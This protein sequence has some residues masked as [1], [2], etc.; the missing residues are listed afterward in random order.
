MLVLTHTDALWV[1]FYK[2]RE[3]V[4][5]APRDGYRGAER[6]IVIRKF[7]RA[8][9]GRRIDARPRLVYDHVGHAGKVADHIGDKYL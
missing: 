9:L 6:N 7:L 8:E 1:N 4:L 5:Q 2:L 3:R